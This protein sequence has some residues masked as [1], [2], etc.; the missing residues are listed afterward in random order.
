MSSISKTAPTKRGGWRRIAILIVGMLTIGLIPLAGSAVA[1]EASPVMAP[2]VAS[3]DGV[4]HDARIKND[5]A[6]VVRIRACKNRVSD[7]KC[8]AYKTDAQ[9]KANPRKWLK[10]GKATPKGQDW[11]GFWCPANAICVVR[12][13]KGVWYE[14]HVSSPLKSKFVP[15]QGCFGCT[16]SVKVTW[17]RGNGGGGGGGW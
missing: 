2:T 9:K 14:T 17:N 13:P 1:P 7:T 15:V 11:D 6:S 10:P 4:G 5:S 8:A 3:A 12:W 16:K